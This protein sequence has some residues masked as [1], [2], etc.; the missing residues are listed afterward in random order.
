LSG[1]ISGDRLV[2]IGWTVQQLRLVTSR[3]G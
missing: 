2:Q 1:S 3:S